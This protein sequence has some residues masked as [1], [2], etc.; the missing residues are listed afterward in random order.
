MEEY[1]ERPMIPAT[2][3]PVLIPK[4]ILSARNKIH[5]GGEKRRIVRKRKGMRREG[6][7]EGLKVN[8]NSNVEGEGP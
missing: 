2:T 7:R 1:L 5:G 6:K 3:G 8:T 4:K